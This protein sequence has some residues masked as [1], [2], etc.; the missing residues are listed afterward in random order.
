MPL[1]NPQETLALVEHIA[2]MITEEE[3]KNGTTSEDAISTLNDLIAGARQITGIDP[4]HP[5]LHCAF[6]GCNVADCDCQ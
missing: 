2:N 4:R 5:K 1:T 3:I 6:C